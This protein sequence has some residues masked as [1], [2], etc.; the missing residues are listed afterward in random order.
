MAKNKGNY[1]KLRSKKWFINKGYVC[2]IVEKLQSIWVKGR[3]IY[4]KRDLFG[5][6]LLA[7]NGEEMIFAN[8]VFGKKN[9]ASHIK[10]FHNYPYPKS[11]KIKR[12]ILSWELRAREP[13][14]TEIE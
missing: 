11:T 9:I 1:Y 4:I 12:W 3:V 13:E 10:E 2:D 5:S 6:D 14:I 8:S 7:M